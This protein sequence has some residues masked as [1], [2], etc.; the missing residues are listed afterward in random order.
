MVFPTRAN[1]QPVALP[2]SKKLKS[3]EQAFFI[4]PDEERG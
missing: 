1:A 4:L 2:G 3:K